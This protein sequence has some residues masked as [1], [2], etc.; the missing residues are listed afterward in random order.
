[1]LRLASYY[2]FAGVIVVCFQNCGQQPMQTL[3]ANSD[4]SVN[5]NDNAAISKKIEEVGQNIDARVKESCV[6]S[7]DCK[8]AAMGVKICGGPAKHLVYSNSGSEE[9]DLLQLVEEY[10]ELSRDYTSHLVGVVG[11]CSFVEAPQSIECVASACVPQ[12]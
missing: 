5:G 6:V 8:S 10:N 12:F 4:G 11:D 1:M 2:I 3:S 9:R 7:A